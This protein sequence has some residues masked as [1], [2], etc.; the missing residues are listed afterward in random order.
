MQ[1]H[2]INDVS[3]DFCRPQILLLTGPPNCRPAMLNLCSQ[4]TKNTSLL[5]CGNV[6]VVSNSTGIMLNKSCVIKVTYPSIY[7][8]VYLSIYLSECMTFAPATIAPVTS[9]NVKPN[10]NPNRN[11]NPYTTL[12]QKANDNPRSYSLLP[13]ISS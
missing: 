10:P 5:L 6:I 11:P 9:A 13:E 12:S 7:L 8:S 3:I 1:V 2:D 4:I